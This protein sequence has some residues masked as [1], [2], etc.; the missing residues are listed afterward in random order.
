MKSM[1]LA[2]RCLRKSSLRPMSWRSSTRPS[3]L[4][5]SSVIA[6]SIATLLPIDCSSGNARLTRSAHSTSSVPISRIGGSKVRTSNR[7][8]ALAVCCIWSM[9]SSIAVIR[10]LIS[11]RSNGVMNVRRTAVSTSRVI[12]SA[13]FSNWLT[14][15]Q[16]TGVSSPPRSMPCNASAPCTTVC[17][18][19]ANRSKNRSSL[20]RKARNQRSITGV[21][22]CGKMTSQGGLSRNC[23]KPFPRESGRQPP[24]EPGHPP[25]CRPEMPRKPVLLERP[26]EIMRDLADHAAPERQHADHKD[27]ALDHRHPLS[28]AGQ[29]L[30][31]GDDDEGTDDRAEHGTE[32]ADQRHQHDLS[33]HRPVHVGERGILRHEH[34][35][36]AGKARQRAGED[37]GE[38]LVL[39]GLVAERDRPLLVFPDRLQHLAERRIDGAKDDQ[40]TEQE[41]GK[42]DVIKHR[43]VREIEK[44][45]QISLRDAL[46]TVFAM[47]ERRLQIDEI[48]QLRQSQRDHRE[49]DALTPDSNEA[50]DDAK[51]GG[52]GG[53]D[54]NSKLGRKAPD[55]HRM[56]GDVARGTQKHR[57]TE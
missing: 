33:G 3:S 31:H 57:V 51:P 18:W 4:V 38:Q 5:S 2:V 44:A 35:E 7:M 43:R 52:T 39:I 45:E 36:R 42:D 23:H 19:R 8:T 17:E 13:S 53:A 22:C 30:L 27:R 54:Q 12:L 14:R 34:L 26:P 20:G 46:D 47:G 25:L 11:P 16:N 50:C 40:K 55:L 24:M 49:I 41:P 1:V 10:F 15:W 29:I 37:V 9:A 6:V 48:Q 32:T 56:R 21:H 28:E